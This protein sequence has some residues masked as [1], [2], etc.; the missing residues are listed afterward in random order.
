MKVLITGGT[1]TISSGLVKECVTRGYETYAITRGSN[2]SRNIGGATYIHGNIWNSQEMIQ[3]LEGELYDV[4][5]DTQVYTVEQLKISLEN[6]SNKCQQYVFIST[7]GIYTRQG[8]KRIVETDEKNFTEWS[9]TRYKIECEKYLKDYS[10]KTGLKYTIVRPTVTYGDFR[11]PFPIATR[12]PGWTFFQRM[13]DGKPMLASDN[14]KFS[15]IHIDDFSSMVV[16]LFG[17]GKAINEDFHIT[18]NDNDI[19]W[20]DMIKVASKVLDC[21]PNIIHVPVET[22]KE[23]WPNIYDEIKYHKN[24]TQLFDDTKILSVTGYKAA[25]DLRNGIQSII[26]AMKNEYKVRK[27]ALDFDW[28]NRCDATIFYAY[29]KDV[30]SK[31]DK[32]RARNYIEQDYTF[33]EDNYKKIVRNNKI[34]NSFLRRLKRKVGSILK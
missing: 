15:I 32:E 21:N 25:I 12:T 17:N 29:K 28:N 5:V 20:D 30:L 16:S 26:S 14:V 10:E 24:T 34:N 1:G 22:L 9:Y 33:F 23:I 31:E 6:F 11:I 27:M 13:L 2:N 7:A 18:C 3:L 4:I 19:Y 8:E